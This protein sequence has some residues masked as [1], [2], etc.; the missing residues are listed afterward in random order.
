MRRFLA[1]TDTLTKDS[2]DGLRRVYP[3][4]VETIPESYNQRSVLHHPID[5]NRVNIIVSSGGWGGPFTLSFC[6]A[7]GM[8]DAAVNGNICAAPSAYDIY[9]TAKK[10]NS[11]HGYLLLYNNFMGD[12]LN[13]DL[14]LELMEKD[15]YRG[16]LIPFNDDCLSVDESAPR[17]ER[18]GLTGIV[19]AAKIAAGHVRT[20]ASLEETE[21]L[22]SYVKSRLSSVM[23]SVDLENETISLGEGISGEPPRY[24]YKDHFHLKDAAKLVYDRL[25]QDLQPKENERIYV[26]INRAIYTFYEDQF[27]LAKYLDEYAEGRIHQMSAGYFFRMCDSY[28]FSVTMMAVDERCWPYMEERCFSDSYI[29]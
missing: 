6:T 19:Y 4:L 17:E 16:K 24:T 8:A 13:N 20:G 10:I 29:L 7:S 11:P 18:T 5:P 12:C 26:L 27:I 25:Y 15:G 3:E 22:L 23:L 1:D 9:E 21:Q 2:M 28:S 14:A